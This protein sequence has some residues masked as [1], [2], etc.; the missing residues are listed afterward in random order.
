MQITSDRKQSQRPQHG[1]PPYKTGTV[2][3]GNE[4][5][6]ATYWHPNQLT[7]HSRIYLHV[8]KV[9]SLSAHVNKIHAYPGYSYFSHT[10]L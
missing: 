7:S 5:L 10:H 9:R 8:Y 3:L 1:Y 6:S 4:F 2:E